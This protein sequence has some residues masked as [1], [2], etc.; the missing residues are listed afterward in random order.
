MLKDV[1]RDFIEYKL[2]ERILALV[3]EMLNVLEFGI[4]DLEIKRVICK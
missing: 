3:G 2:N 4:E 1:N